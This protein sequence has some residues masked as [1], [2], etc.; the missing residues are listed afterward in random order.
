MTRRLI[1]IFKDY[2]RQEEV[3]EIKLKEKPQQASQWRKVGQKKKTK[4]IT[5]TL[6]EVLSE[7]NE[8]REYEANNYKQ[9][10]Q[11][12]PSVVS[13][14]STSKIKVIDMTGKEQKILHGYESLSKKNNM[15]H[16][17]VENFNET[18]KSKQNI[19]DLPEL[20]HNLEILVNMTEEKII[21]S[22]RQYQFSSFI[23]FLIIKNNFTKFQDEI[24]RRHGFK[25]DTRREK[26]K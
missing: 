6:D 12:K 25:Y 2:E 7:T 24:Q 9:K 22:D 3:E 13:G 5:K 21:Q 14:I 18:G 15:L 20:L 11:S 26:D 16:D 17:E 23:I 19:F 10:V 1:C 8:T 4:Y